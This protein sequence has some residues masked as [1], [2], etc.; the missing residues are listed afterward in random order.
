MAG[1]LDNTASPTV[2]SPQQSWANMQ[3]ATGQTP[4]PQGAAA[5]PAG[6]LAPSATDVATM[7]PGAS[8]LSDTSSRVNDMATSQGDI[9][10]ANMAK[11]S[12]INEAQWLLN[13]GIPGGQSAGAALLANAKGIDPSKVNSGFIA[14]YTAA[15][16]LINRAAGVDQNQQK[17]NLVG[18]Q[19][20]WARTDRAE[21]RNVDAGMRDAAK[22]GG[23]EGVVDFLKTADPDR[24][25]TFQSAKLDLDKKIMSTD[26]YSAL[27]PVE[28]AKALFEG[29]GVL[30]KM[31]SALLNAP[32][33]DRSNMYQTM[34]PM[35]K[36]INPQASST[37]DGNAVSMFMLAAA[38]ATPENILFDANKRLTSSGTSIE[39]ID[40]AIS[41][42]LKAGED[43]NSPLMKDLMA[44]REI[45]TNKVQQSRFTLQ[46]AQNKALGQDQSN[47]KDAAQAQS[48]QYTL[49]SKM[50]KDLNDQSKDYNDYLTIKSDLDGS[51]KTLEQN[52]GKGG[53]AQ[54]TAVK[55]LARVFAGNKMVR[56]STVQ[57]M[58]HSAGSD[59]DETVKKLQSIN[60]QD[61]KVIL[62]PEEVGQL[63]Q[64]NQN[65]AQ[66]KWKQ[67]QERN[68]FYSKQASQ[69]LKNPSDLKLPSS[70]FAPT[71]SAPVTYTLPQIQ[72]MGA[73]ALKSG[74]D[75]EAVRQMM[76]KLIQQSVGATSGGAANGQQ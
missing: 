76:D 40:S 10:P 1:L 5:P 4:Q 23:F 2:V 54:I 22:Q 17:L 15:D 38:Q 39:K 66:E 63:K 70:P 58:I 18:E 20:S 12:R 59:V 72:Q 49:V 16:D 11:D 61:G 57:S 65:V 53:L 51:L 41:T 44:Q 56:D 73:G 48:T 31:G 45:E 62:S 75:P 50:N 36:T 55:A 3:S 27:L 32:E 7:S 74:K 14:G 28:K 69:Y 60:G 29:Y 19:Q 30:G 47:A 68:D 26:L 46:A 13:S 64:L 25:M 9:N 33:K 8:L 42:R 21:K 52:G 35:I 71:P 67:Q 6:L 34:L 24:A 37:L 43:G